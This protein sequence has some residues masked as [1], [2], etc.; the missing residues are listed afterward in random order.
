V[1]DRDWWAALAGVTLLAA[2]LRLA[3]IRAV[4]L[5]PYY[6]AAVRS[7]GMSWHN[8]FYGAFDPSGRVA[9]DK[10]PVDLWLQVLSVKLLGFK[11]IALKAPAVLAATAAAALLYDTVRRMFG[12]A[13][14]RVGRPAGLLSATALAVMPISVLT[15]RSDTM[16]SL[17]MALLVASAWLVVLAG[18]RGSVGLLALAGAVLG[19]AF[20][21]KLL[22]IFVAV[23]ALAV[24][25]WLLPFGAGSRPGRLAAATAA[26]VVTA[27]AWMTVVSLTPRHDRPYPLGSTD[28]SVWTAVF[29]FNGVDR[30]LGRAEPEDFGE[31]TATSA[32]AQTPSSA[33]ATVVVHRRRAPLKAPPGPIRLFAHNE[34]EYDALIGELLLG[35][36]VFGGLALAVCRP[37]LLVRDGDGRRRC[38]R[39]GAGV[40]SLTVWLLTGYVIFSFSSRLHPRYLEAFTPAVAAAL[41]A[42][43]AALGAR[44]RRRRALGAL[45]TGVAALALFAF[46]LSRDVRTIETHASDEALAPGLTATTVSG[47]SAFL[48]THQRAAR[49]EFAGAAPT[50]AAPV[51]VRDARPMLLLEGVGS[52][53]LVTVAQLRRYVEQGEVRYVLGRGVCPNAADRGHPACSPLLLWVQ[54]HG[55]DVSAQLGL[56]RQRAG[57]LYEVGPQTA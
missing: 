32:A 49:Y 54:E 24:L 14:A 51:I 42:G 12:A 47:L 1:R 33:R 44:A 5:D 13:H 28:G 8:F 9:I 15:S 25:A 56:P 2:V 53:P 21:V 30:V 48:R 55:R 50:Q 52:R 43:L 4:P 36:I 31:P 10:P 23:P 45:L 34:L 39:A 37:A 22:E 11:P 17:M 7:M 38:T 57:L 26:F 40:A 35:A 19:V 27:L 20:N 16:D 6:D 18:E 29:V 3:D 46:A 41:G